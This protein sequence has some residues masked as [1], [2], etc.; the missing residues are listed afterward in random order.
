[1]AATSEP[2]TTTRPEV[3]G[4]LLYFLRLG[5]FGFGGPIALVEYMQRDCWKNETG[6]REKT[7]WRASRFRSCVREHSRRSLQNIWDGCTAEQWA[8][9][10]LELPGGALGIFTQTGIENESFWYP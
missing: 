8:Q 7:I 9:R 5:T 6:F 2:G 3:R 4:L 1:M 10:L